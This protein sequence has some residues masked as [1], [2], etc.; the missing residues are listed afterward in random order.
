V[1]RLASGLPLS[2]LTLTNL[3]DCNM[4]RYYSLYIFVNISDSIF[5]YDAIQST[6]PPS[7]IYYPEEG[8]ERIIL[9]WSSWRIK[10]ECHQ[11]RSAD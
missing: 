9:V 6:K 8:Y 2:N 7:N 3:E 10:P 1:L 4:K 5:F 11:F